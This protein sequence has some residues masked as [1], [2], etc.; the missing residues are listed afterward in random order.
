MSSPVIKD[1]VQQGK[2]RLVT[3]W[4]EKDVVQGLLKS[5]MEN[6]QTVE[7]IYQQLLDERSVFTAIGEQLNVVGLLVGEARDG[8]DDSAY[9]EAILNRVAINTSDGT[10]EKVIEIMKT[11]IAGPNSVTIFEHYP[12]NIH[13][14]TTAG[15]T[16]VN[17]AS[18][19]SIAPVGVNARLMFDDGIVT[20][21]GA[22][23]T[24]DSTANLVTENLDNIEVEEGSGPFELE[25]TNRVIVPFGDN[26]SFPHL[27]ET[28]I[29]NPLCA[30]LSTKLLLTTIGIITDDL[31][32]LLTDESGNFIE[33][34]VIEEVI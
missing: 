21:I 23:V 28:G 29:I 25:V 10:P 1:Q 33:Y 26:A 31:N 9:R 14:H 12:A 20:W 34:Q 11:I 30:V 13:V 15:A 7:D 32:N 3:Q 24:S 5:Y 6:V 22:A 18:L 8:K 27:L 4:S 17:A 2:D 19:N 16:N